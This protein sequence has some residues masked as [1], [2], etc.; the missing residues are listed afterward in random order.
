MA[1]SDQVP[2]GSVFHAK[3]TGTEV[4]EGIDLAGK[5]AVV[6]GGYSGLGLEVVRCLAAKGAKV[7][8]PVRTE[9]KAR[10]ALAGISGDV[11]TAPMDLRRLSASS[12]SSLIATRRFSTVTSSLH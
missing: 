9:D 10:Q 5:T 8:V 6:T 1:V 7:I 11:S 2:T 4:V 12:G 3:S